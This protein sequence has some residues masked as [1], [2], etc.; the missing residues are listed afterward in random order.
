MIGTGR[1]SPARLEAITK[2]VVDLTVRPS[3]I[4]QRAVLR[5]HLN[6][7]NHH[8]VGQAWVEVHDRVVQPMMENHVPKRIPPQRA[9][10]TQL[11]RE[12]VNHFPTELTQQLQRRLLHQRIL[13]ILLRTHATVSNNKSRSSVETSIC[14]DTSLGRRRSR[15]V[16]KLCSLEPKGQG[17]SVEGPD[18]VGKLQHQIRRRDHRLYLSQG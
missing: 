1:I 8:G 17:L 6:R 4:H 13:G 2:E 5:H 16:E 9:R 7:L 10:R 12:R 18:R 11:L 3:A 14:P 15:R